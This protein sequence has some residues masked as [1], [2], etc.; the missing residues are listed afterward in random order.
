MKKLLLGTTFLH[1]SIRFAFGQDDF[2]PEDIP[3]GGIWI[4]RAHSVSSFPDYRISLN[5]ASGLHY[6]LKLFLKGRPW[7][8]REWRTILWSAF[9]ADHPEEAA[10]YGPARERS[11]SAKAPSPGDLSAT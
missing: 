5:T 6:D 4:S 9:L 3:A 7:T 8:D 2:N 1:E 11:G 10:G